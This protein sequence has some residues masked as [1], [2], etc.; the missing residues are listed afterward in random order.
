ME[1]VGEHLLPGQLGHFFTILSLVASLTATIAFFKATNT[2]DLNQKNSWLRLARI[3]FLAETVSV[4]AIF[5]S[6]LIFGSYMTSSVNTY[7]EKLF[8]RITQ[9]E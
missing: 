7:T 5:A 2:T 3:A 1:F 8:T 9:L 4:F 6:L